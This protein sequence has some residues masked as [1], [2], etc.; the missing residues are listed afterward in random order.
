MAEIKKLHAIQALPVILKFGNVDP[1][2]R[3]PLL[4]SQCILGKLRSVITAY[5]LLQFYMN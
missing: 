3:T 2:Y 5:N 1:Y 4:S